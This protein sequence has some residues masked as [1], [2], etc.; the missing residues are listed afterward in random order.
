MTDKIDYIAE[1]ITDSLGE[2]CPEHSDGCPTCEAW[3][4]YDRLTGKVAVGDLIKILSTMDQNLY[5]RSVSISV[6]GQSNGPYELN[7]EGYL[8]GKKVILV[9]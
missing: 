6:V 1:A 4:Q 2:R 9:S 3:A 8:S 5:V 7:D